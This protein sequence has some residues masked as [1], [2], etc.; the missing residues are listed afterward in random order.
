MSARQ[1]FAFSRR[2]VLCVVSLWSIVG[3]AVAGSYAEDEDVDR[4]TLRGLSGV[5]VVI[6]SVRPE[7]E[8]AGLTKQQL[9]TDVELRLRQT[10]IRVLSKA[11][12]AQ[13]LGWPF[14][15]VN[16]HVLISTGMAIYNIRVDLKQEAQL[17]ANDSSAVVSTWSTG[18]LGRT[19]I[20][21]MPTDVR[22]SLR[23]R[24]D[25][26]VNAYLSVNPSVGP[27]AA[28]PAAPATPSPRRDLIRQV[29]QRLQAV[30]YNPGTADGTMGPQTRNALR[31][32][33]NTKGLRPT[34]EPDEA[35]LDALGV[36]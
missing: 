7:I 12:R 9:Q 1:Y 19:G 18:S 29:Q 34:G 17:S 32:F 3:L 22:N 30:G 24:V 13:V 20:A 14:L 27:R 5:H 28:A 25:E 35:T 21:N 8:R 10:G 31:W 36:R 11:E 33:Q 15:Y 16:V 6:E 23:D 4:D 2:R 26:F